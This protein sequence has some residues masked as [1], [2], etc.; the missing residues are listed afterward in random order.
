MI[1]FGMS[2]WEYI[3]DEVGQCQDHNQESK[4]EGHCANQMKDGASLA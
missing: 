3:G 4:S 2:A 1:C